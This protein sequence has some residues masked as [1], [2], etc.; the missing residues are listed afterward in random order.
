[1]TIV[2]QIKAEKIQYD[3]NSEASKIS[4]ASPGKTNKYE[5]LAGE[6]ILPFNQKQIIEQANFTYSPF[7]KAFEEQTKTVKDQREKQIK[8]I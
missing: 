3:I 6:E 2:D 5:Y 8:A 7:G 4:A 1:M